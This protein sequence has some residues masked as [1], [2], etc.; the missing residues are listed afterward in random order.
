MTDTAYLHRIEYFRRQ[1][2][3]SLLCEHVETVDDHGWYIARGE[4][5]RAHYTRGCAEEFLARQDAQPGVYSVAVWRG[6]TRV[7][8][9]GLH[10]TG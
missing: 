7:C 10:W 4:E 2:N 9:V 8:T 3:G 1:R 5:W 6:P